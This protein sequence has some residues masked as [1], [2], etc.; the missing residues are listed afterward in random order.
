MKKLCTSELNDRHGN[1]LNVSD[2]E[3]AILVARS[4]RSKIMETLAIRRLRMLH[5]KNFRIRGQSVAS[6]IFD[7]VMERWSYASNGELTNPETSG[8]FIASVLSP[9]VIF[10]PAVISR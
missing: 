9:W 10:L 5:A 4:R 7:S 2:T 3:A 6:R 8:A 1:K